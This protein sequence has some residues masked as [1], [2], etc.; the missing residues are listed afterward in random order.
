MN[1]IFPSFFLVLCAV[2]SAVWVGWAA[3]GSNWS[4]LF[5]NRSAQHF[6]F[7]SSLV[8]AAFWFMQAGVLPGLSFHILALTA[9][10]LMMGWRLT[11]VAATL[12]QLGLTLV[13]QVE[14]SMLGYQLLFGCL[15][16][17]AF[18]FWFYCMVYKR[19]THNPFIYILVAG[20]LNAGFTH[21]F[22]DLINSA[23]YWLAGSYSLGQIWYDYLRYLPLMMFPEGVV[24]GM[25]IS[26][27]VAF[28]SRW[29]STFDEDS[30][31]S[32]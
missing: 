6:F 14:W 19:L 5:S 2:V 25:F 32:K 24:N 18:S 17:I 23:S 28:H 22:S 29:L 1:G 16:P 12:T 31:F 3:W 15:M 7:G 8:M 13:G 27:M 11:M 4:A 9:V 30:Y 26:G 21:A 20:F 10:T